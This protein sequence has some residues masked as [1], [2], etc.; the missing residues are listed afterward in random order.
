MG[1]YYYCYIYFIL[2][3]ELVI[4]ILVEINKSTRR[5]YELMGNEEVEKS[6]K[7]GYE[8][9]QKVYMPIEFLRELMKEVDYLT[10]V[11]KEAREKEIIS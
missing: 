10:D 1:Y 9:S 11:E 5:E 8:Q 3:K 6:S 7:M 4:F 2:R